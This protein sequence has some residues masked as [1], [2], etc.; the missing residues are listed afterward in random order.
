MTSGTSLIDS[1]LTLLNSA[2]PV[3]VVVGTGETAGR[4]FPLL[5]KV[6]WGF[7]TETANHS[8]LL[9]LAVRRTCGWRVQLKPGTYCAS[10]VSGTCSLRGIRPLVYN[11]ANDQFWPARSERPPKLRSQSTV[12]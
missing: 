8:C 3:I 2:P 6:V 1:W 7:S 11:V 10:M 5:K 9:M 4:N 12:V